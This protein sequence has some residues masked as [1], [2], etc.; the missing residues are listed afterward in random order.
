M[1]EKVMY[2]PN[3]QIAILWSIFDVQTVR[4]DLSNKK[5]YA[6]LKKAEKMHDSDQGINWDILKIWADELF[7]QK[8]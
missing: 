8:K 7:P 5:A 3:C 1:L 6:V 2:D 4:P